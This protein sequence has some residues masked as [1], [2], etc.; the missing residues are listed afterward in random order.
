VPA[1]RGLH[2]LHLALAALAL[3]AALAWVLVTWFSRTTPELWQRDWHCF[4]TVGGSYL[5]G[6]REGL[7]AEPCKPGYFWLYPPYVVYPW[8]ALA[9]LPAGYAYL[10]VSAAST[11]AFLVSL[12]FLRR[13]LCWD[14]PFVTIFL[15]S[16]GSAAFN[17]VLVTGQHTMWLL[18]GACGGLWALRE[19]RDALAG[20]FLAL[21]GIKP[22]W[23][24]FFA[25]WL[26]VTGRRRALGVMVL[27]GAGLVLTTAPM[28]PSVWHAY[29]TVSS[30]RLEVLLGLDAGSGSYPSFK[31]ITAEAFLRSVGL[32]SGGPAL[33]WS[34]L[35]A[36]ALCVA[37][38]VFVWSRVRDARVQ[39]A[40]TVLACVAANPYVEFYDALVLVVPAA[41]WWAAPGSYPGRTGLVVAFAAISIWLVQWISL[42]LWKAPG[43]PSLVGGLLLI[44]IAAETVRAARAREPADPGLLP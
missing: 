44:W 35:A 12:A 9:L 19:R 39:I 24:I 42:Y 23:A 37:A 8:A 43:Q 2:A 16:T 20:G 29:L 11:L 21:F 5:R 28:G 32:A 18:L 6:V 38:S 7:Y 1:N 10:L 22:N 13:T 26:L 15:A 40:I 34:A 17:A 30:T 27:A 3:A 4:W 31:L 36:I 33:G 25:L 14:R 41:T